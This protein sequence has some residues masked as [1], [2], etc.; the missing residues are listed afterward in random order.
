MI[1]LCSDRQTPSA[2]CSQRPREGDTPQSPGGAG[3]GAGGGGREE[4][5]AEEEG[6]SCGGGTE[7]GGQRRGAAGEPGLHLLQEDQ[8]EELQEEL[9]RRGELSP[10]QLHRVTD[11]FYFEISAGNSEH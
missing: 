1:H 4:D 2:T 8:T 5:G 11:G 9:S 3:G 6:R 10:D 7:A